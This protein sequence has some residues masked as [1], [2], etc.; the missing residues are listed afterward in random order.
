[1]FEFEVFRAEYSDESS[2]VVYLAGE[3]ESAVE[4]FSAARFFAWNCPRDIE[5]W[6]RK[7]GESEWQKFDVVVESVPS[8]VVERKG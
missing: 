8:F 4:Q 3:I 6:A 5:I 1:M 2:A 7:V